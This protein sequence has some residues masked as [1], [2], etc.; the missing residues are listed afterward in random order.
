VKF[1]DLWSLHFDLTIKTPAGAKE[2][3]PFT[4]PIDEVDDLFDSY[5]ISREMN[6][7]TLP[8]YIKYKIGK[9][10]L[11]AGG[12]LGYLTSATDVYSGKTK[13]EDDY[14]MNRKVLEYFNRWDAGVTAMIDYYFDTSKAMKSLRLGLKYYYGLT[15]I[16]KDNP[17]DSINNSIFLLSLGI[18]VG[19]SGEE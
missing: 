18:P 9:F 14:T 11:G 3:A 6:Y 4:D 16:V 10:K 17:G 8:V 12:Q 15:D 7:I 1:S 13:Y 19:G 5:T 2:V